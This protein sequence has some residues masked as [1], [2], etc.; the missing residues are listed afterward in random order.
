ML[1]EVLQNLPER[2][3][4]DKHLPWDN[5]S[6]VNA[7]ELPPD[8]CGLES[9]CA[10]DVVAFITRIVGINATASRQI[11]CARCDGGRRLNANAITGDYLPIENATPKPNDDVTERHGRQD[12]VAFEETVH[13]DCGD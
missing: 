13:L 1:R 7:P 4:R 12:L 6:I 5:P 3:A 8:R 9:V 2:S 11:A 10:E